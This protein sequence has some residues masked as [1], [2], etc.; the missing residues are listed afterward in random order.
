VPDEQ[1]ICSLW[2]LQLT[3]EGV[4]KLAAASGDPKKTAPCGRNSKDAGAF[5]G[6]TKGIIDV[7]KGLSLNDSF[8]IVPKGFAGRLRNTTL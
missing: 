2:D 1:S 4:L 3:D 6:N 8:W 7:C 5:V